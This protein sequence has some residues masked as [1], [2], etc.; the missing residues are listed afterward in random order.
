MKDKWI[1][2][3]VAAVLISSTAGVALGAPEPRKDERWPTPRREQPRKEGP[4]EFRPITFYCCDERGSVRCS[5]N[6]PGPVGE[7][8]FCPGVM[9]T[10]TLCRDSGAAPSR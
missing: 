7:R 4:E 1:V 9:G 5:V 6:A 2:P 3:L 10:G 8:C